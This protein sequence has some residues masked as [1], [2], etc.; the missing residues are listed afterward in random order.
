MLLALLAPRHM[1]LFKKH[2]FGDM[3]YLSRLKG[4][5]S[6]KQKR[7]CGD[8]PKLTQT[9]QDSQAANDTDALPDGAMER[10]RQVVLKMLRENPEITRAWTA[11]GSADPIRVHLAIRGKGSCELSVPADRWDEFKFLELLE[12]QEG[13]A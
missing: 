13:T 8:V 12:K 2:G 3:S 10:R 5:I 9:Y 7:P 1:A 11:D 4:A 6:E